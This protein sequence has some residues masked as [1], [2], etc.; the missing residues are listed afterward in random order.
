MAPDPP[1]DLITLQLSFF[2]Q[3]FPHCSPSLRSFSLV[4][5]NPAISC[6]KIEGDGTSS[7]W[8][9]H[10][11]VRYRQILSEQP[12]LY[13]RGRLSLSRRGLNF[14]SND[15]IAPQCLSAKPSVLFRR[16]SSTFHLLHT[17]VPDAT[18]PSI[19]APF[20]STNFDSYRSLNREKSKFQLRNKEI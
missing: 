11:G 3:R 17:E 7:R 6:P 8:N 5:L 1:L 12:L 20:R 4:P 10:A 15:A 13:A 16:K 19:D 9:S 18:E 14:G 2:I